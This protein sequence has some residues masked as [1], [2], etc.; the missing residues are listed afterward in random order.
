MHHCFAFIAELSPVY[1]CL[2][3]FTLCNNILEC[4]QSQ[5]HESCC[6][7][8]PGSSQSSPLP[9]THLHTF[10]PEIVSFNESGNL[11]ICNLNISLLYKLLRC[12]LVV[13]FVCY[14]TIWCQ[15]WQNQVKMLNAIVNLKRYEIFSWTVFQLFLLA[16]NLISRNCTS[17]SFFPQCKF[18]QFSQNISDFFRGTKIGSNSGEV[19]GA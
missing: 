15:W 3:S 17:G 12:H 13:N 4:Q 1:C 14:L 6:G 16:A 18:L 2:V 11:L 5:T 10:A 7:L 19:L 8:S 9:Q